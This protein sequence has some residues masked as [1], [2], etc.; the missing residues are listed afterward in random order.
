MT[1]KYDTEEETGEKLSQYLKRGIYTNDLDIAW[2]MNKDQVKLTQEKIFGIE[3]SEFTVSSK[4]I[5]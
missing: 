2:K 1:A 3:C 5:F 4:S